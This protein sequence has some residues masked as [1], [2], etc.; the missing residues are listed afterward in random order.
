MSHR[1]GAQRVL[2]GSSDGRRPLERCRRRWEDNTKINFQVVGWEAWTGLIWLRI[3]TAAGVC[4]C[5]NESSGSIKRGKFLNSRGSVSF[6][7][8]T[9]LHR[10]S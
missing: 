9:Q 5:G 8:R 4:E 3:G 10:G 1:R 6:S 2:V 7:G